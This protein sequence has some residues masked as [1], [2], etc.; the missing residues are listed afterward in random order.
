MSTPEPVRHQRLVGFALDGAFEIEAAPAALPFDIRSRFSSGIA[1]ERG[2][3]LRVWIFRFGAVVQEGADDPDPELV[4]LVERATGRKALLDLVERLTVQVDPER[5]ATNPRTGWDSVAVGQED[6]ATMG[7][8]AMLLG[9]STALERYERLVTR[10]MESSL[11]LVRVLAREGK[12]PQRAR[13]MAKRVG[14]IAEGRLE[15]GQLFFFVDRP[16]EAWERADI[17]ALFDAL[18]TAFELRERHQAVLHKL[19]AVESANET[20]LGLWFSSR[21]HKLEWAIVLLIVAEIVMF[22]AGIG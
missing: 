7:A 20:T 15:L 2:G 12:T 5:A 11:D 13:G 9:Q 14:A 10:L 1:L 4:A 8:I 18:S 19:N 16:D 22:L 3:G 21:G 17:S 6:A